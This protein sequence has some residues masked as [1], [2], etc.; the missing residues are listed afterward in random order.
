[1]KFERFGKVV[2]GVVRI[3]DRVG[4]G[5]VL[6]TPLRGA[7]DF[8]PLQRLHEE[9]PIGL[10]VPLPSPPPTYG[11]LGQL[12]RYRETNEDKELG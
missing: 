11:T 12:T 10:E 4:L 2:E 3:A 6:D 9:M 5:K 7:P 1:M 8:T